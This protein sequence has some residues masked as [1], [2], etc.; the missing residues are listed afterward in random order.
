MITIGVIMS[1]GLILVDVPFDT[2]HV[3]CVDTV[4]TPVLTQDLVELRVLTLPTVVAFGYQRSSTSDDTQNDENP[5]AH[6]IELKAS[7]Y[8]VTK[9]KLAKKDHHQLT[10]TYLIQF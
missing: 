6:S 8:F 9:Q 5:S 3:S 2:K 10:P 1:P 7:N 4:P